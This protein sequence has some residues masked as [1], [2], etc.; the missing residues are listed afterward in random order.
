MSNSE[1]SPLQVSVSWNANRTILL[2]FTP[3]ENTWKFPN[4]KKLKLFNLI[5]NKISKYEQPMT[6]D[7]QLDVVNT[8]TEVDET[9]LI[10]AKSIRDLLKE[11]VDAGDLV[12]E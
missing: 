12:L 4:G 2:T 6:I 5:H 7:Y 11:W 1:E 3:S 10:I 8:E 9:L